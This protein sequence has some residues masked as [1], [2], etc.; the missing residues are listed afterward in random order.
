MKGSFPFARGSPGQWSRRAPPP[1]LTS[2]FSFIVTAAKQRGRLVLNQMITPLRRLQSE[3]VATAHLG[4]E[5]ITQGE[6]G[7]PPSLPRPHTWHC[8]LP[9]G[10]ATGPSLHIPSQASSEG[11]RNQLSLKNTQTASKY[12]PRL[13]SARVKGAS[14]WSARRTPTALQINI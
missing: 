10:Q 3:C 7:E 13:P 6:E 12:Y 2:P 5:P 14:V 1:P 4:L 11:E 8:L 9:R